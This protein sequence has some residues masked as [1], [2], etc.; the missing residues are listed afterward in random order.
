MQLPKSNIK[1]VCPISINYE[2]FLRGRNPKKELERTL[3]NYLFEVNLKEDYEDICL[4]REVEK[5][6]AA[7]KNRSL[8]HQR[9]NKGL[10]NLSSN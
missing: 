5:I 4:Y 10:D 8:S 2:D 6:Q 7:V 3:F 1:S 9:S